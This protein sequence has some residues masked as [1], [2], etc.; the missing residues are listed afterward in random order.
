VAERDQRRAQDQLGQVGAEAGARSGGERQVGPGRPAGGESLR[1]DEVRVVPQAGIVM[2]EVGRVEHQRSGGYWNAGG[3][4]VPGGDPA[5]EPAGRVAPQDLIEEQRQGLRVAPL[6]VARQV[7]GGPRQRVAGGVV[8]GGQRDPQV[9]DRLRGSR[10]VAVAYEIKKIKRGKFERKLSK[11]IKK[12]S[13]QPRPTLYAYVY[14]YKDKIRYNK[15]F[16]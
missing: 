8:A 16:E 11:E 2:G 4:A 13:D 14:A 3:H 15:E 12:P 5:A 6:R 10:A 7:P 1:P 9:L